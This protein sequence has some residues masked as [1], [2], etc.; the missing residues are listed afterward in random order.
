M[1]RCW[2]VYIP[3]ASGSQ[4]QFNPANYRLANPSNRVPNGCG[5]IG[6]QICSIFAPN[7]GLTPTSPLSANL[8]DY[9][10]AALVNG[11]CQ[12]STGFAFVYVKPIV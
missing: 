12:P 7:C 4:P 3:P 8:N 11:T 6:G 10:T 5:C 2:Y 9:I 1:A